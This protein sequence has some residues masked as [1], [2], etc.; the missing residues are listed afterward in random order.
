MIRTGKGGRPR[1]PIR[2]KRTRRLQVLLTEAENKALSRL[3]ANRFMTV[4]EVI[5]SSIQ[6]LVAETNPKTARKGGIR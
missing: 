3:A 6:T 2:L 4:S 1:K 5:R